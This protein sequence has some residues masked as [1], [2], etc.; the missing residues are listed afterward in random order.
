MSHRSIIIIQIFK[1]S[2]SL[3]E[4]TKGKPENDCKQ[5]VAPVKVEALYSDP[6]KTGHEL[7]RLLATN[8]MK[9]KCAIVVPQSSEVLIKNI[10]I[11]PLSDKSMLKGVVNSRLQ[12]ELK[13]APEDMA[14]DCTGVISGQQ[15]NNI[16]LAGL[17]KKRLYCLQSVV[18]NANLDLEAVVPG[19]AALFLDQIDT[20]TDENIIYTDERTAKIIVVKQGGIKYLSTVGSNDGSRQS[21][22][23]KVVGEIQRNPAV[24]TAEQGI[25]RVA[26]K[27]PDFIDLLK[28]G[29]GT[30]TKFT[31]STVLYRSIADSIAEIYF[32]DKSFNLN[33]TEN[34]FAEKVN[35]RLTNNIR[36]AILVCVGLL[37]FTGWFIF[38][39][40][41]DKVEIANSQAVIDDL[42]K[43]VEASKIIIEK[44][45]K[46]R[47]WCSTE[48]YYSEC[49]KQITLEFPE[50]SNIWANSLALDQDFVGVMTG[51]ST[52]K[53]RIE[54]T[55][56]RL[57]ANPNFSNVKLL[58]IRQSGKS[59]TDLSFALQFKYNISK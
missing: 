57:I 34:H 23:Q 12:R 50:Q 31:A 51:S 39:W 11:P 59:S 33:F 1:E 28:A 25:F 35:T 22:A 38:D 41:Q 47:Q 9:A 27:S 7:A 37:L 16:V 19:E 10:I 40:Q 24:N 21:L 32:S 5:V 29:I 46:A 8:N 48:A 3:F 36:K 20:A 26:S 6:V 15:Q 30:E 54:S 17:Q 18:E 53:Q 14:L 52:N 43:S 58:Y 42:S 56:D 2:I 49:L 45:N 13:L 44:V 55:I 4:Y